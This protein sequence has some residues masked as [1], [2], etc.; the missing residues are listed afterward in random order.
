MLTIIVSLAFVLLIAY[1]S[2]N[3]YTNSTL[4]DVKQKVIENNPE[5]R[6]IEKISSIGGWGEW[7][8]EFVLVVEINGLK[9]RIWTSKNGE[10]QDK[11]SL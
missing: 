11:E 6:S 9:Y 10:I 7:Y 4:D 2:I 5:I 8:S 3:I 1:F